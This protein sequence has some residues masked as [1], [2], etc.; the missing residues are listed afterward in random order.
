[1][2]CKPNPSGEHSIYIELEIEESCMAFEK[3]QI[4]L[5][6]DLYSPTSN[7][8]FSQKRI[9]SSSDKC[10]I[11]KEFTVKDK[12]QIPEISDGSLL[13]VEVVPSL[14]NTTITNSKITYSGDLNLNFIFTNESS[15]NS[16]SAKMPF[17][18]SVDNENRSDKINVETDI[19]V[20]STNFEIQSRGEASGEIELLLDAR[21]SKNVNMNIIDNVDMSEC[22]N[23]QNDEDYDSLILYIAKPGDSLWKIAKKFNST[24]D[25]LTR[26]NGIENPE[27]IMVGQKIYI[28]KFKLIK[29]E[30][31]EDAR[32]Q[33]IV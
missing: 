8:E 31:N 17:E 13:D 15:V 18:F 28:P 4:S 27:A 21:T 2:L 32:E 23:E 20:Q 9:S 5:I 11:S 16:R 12:V 33:V 10:E 6:Q 26:M 24:V 22:T 14:V 19:S 1:M 25:E 7:L 30:Y 3:R 29:K